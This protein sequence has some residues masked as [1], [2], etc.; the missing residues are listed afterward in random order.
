MAE[1]TDA[2]SGS[3]R[4]S[5]PGLPTAADLVSLAEIHSLLQ[6]FHHDIK[7][8]TK[9]LNHSL[10]KE[11]LELSARTNCMVGQLHKIMAHH[12]NLADQHQELL[13]GFKRLKLKLTDLEDRSLHNVLWIRGI[14]EDSTYRLSKSSKQPKVT[15]CD[16]KGACL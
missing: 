14:L 4:P 8:S 7:K 3:L 6:E 2:A 9:G 12:N 1:Q 10:I 13:S 5:T 11:M 16:H 15:P